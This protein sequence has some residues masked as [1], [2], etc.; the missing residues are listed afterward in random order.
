MVL[1]VAHES[2]QNIISLKHAQ[3]TL[4]SPPHTPM[5]RRHAVLLFSALIWCVSSPSSHAGQTFGGAA[6]RT[7]IRADALAH[8]QHQL[9]VPDTLALARATIAHAS[10]HARHSALSKTPE[11]LFEQARDALINRQDT[12]VEA[13]LQAALDDPQLNATYQDSARLMLARLY[14]E[15]RRPHDALPLLDR[16]GTTPIR[17]YVWWTH[18]R[19]L[20]EAGRHH[21]AAR[22]YERV[23]KISASPMAHR[24][25]VMRAHA[26][27]KAQD[28]RAAADALASTAKLYPDY[29]RRHIQLAQ[30]A[31]T[32]ERL[33]QPKEA[34]SVY[35]TL[36]LDYPFRREG[37][38]ARQRLDALS[39]KGVRPRA[40]SREERYAKYRHLRWFRHWGTARE[41]LQQ[42]ER[43]TIEADGLHAELTHRIWFQLALNAYWPKDYTEAIHYLNK[44]ADAYEKGHRDGLNPY[45]F[46]RYR[47]FSLARIGRFKDALT[48]LDRAYARASE[49][50]RTLRRANFLAEHGKYTEARTLYTKVKPDSWFETWDG[51]WLLYKTR[52]YERAIE[53]FLRLADQRSRWSSSRAR[54]LY[55]AARAE[56]RR[57]RTAEARKLFAQVRLE[58]ADTYYGIQANNR[59]HDMRQRERFL[60][61][62][63]LQTDTLVRG[64][65]ALQELDRPVASAQHSPAS[66]ERAQP[67][68]VL[69]QPA[70]DVERALLTPM[71][72][73][74]V[75]AGHETL[76]CAIASELGYLP[77]ALPPRR[78]TAP[79]L[80]VAAHTPA[81]S[82]RTLIPTPNIPLYHSKE[83]ARDRIPYAA[84]ARIYW[85][86]RNDSALAFARYEDGEAI[87]PVPSRLTAYDETSHVGGLERA[88]VAAGELFGELGRAQWLFRIGMRKQARWAIRD[89]ALEYRDLLAK[90]RPQRAPHQ[91]DRKRMVP[92]ID[93]RKRKLAT[94]GYTEEEHRWPVPDNARARKALLERQQAIYDRRRELR[95]I[96]IDAFKEV[97]DYYMVRRMTLDGGYSGRQRTMQLWPRAFPEEV[98]PAAR[99]FGINPYLVWGIMTTESTYNPDSISWARAIGLMQVI[100]RTGFK[101]AQL[102]GEE[103]FGHDDLLEEDVAIRH[104]AFYLGR[105]VRKFNG[106]ELFAMAGYNGGPHRISDMIDQRGD[107]PLDEFIEEIPFNEARNYAKK[108]TRTIA[109]YLRIY[110]GIDELYIGQNIRREFT[111]MPNF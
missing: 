46:Y 16:I 100:P 23:A 85:E 97:G 107:M 36:W 71:R 57:G 74:P 43:E 75:E 4:P 63:A 92:Y 50:E 22:Y 38:Q 104:G 65:S 2:K 58:H 52:D 102:L 1:V 111:Y 103:H 20:D 49:D 53:V 105:L 48:D 5:K 47:A 55:W 89:V 11:A 56:E 67:R 12:E 99:R 68:T 80:A 51:A 14:L 39:S 66:D 10:R 64:T 101:T 40:L 3:L 21:D 41:L 18:A 86:G 88:V 94:W 35:Q 84:E 42:L 87:G 13:L 95:P 25:R 17:D 27:Y 62:F 26:L 76:T 44:C 106:Q 9:H 77:A 91:L 6:A 32:Y 98:I 15:Q 83:N 60:G 70:E 69:L 93:L 19:A 28:W 8:V 79:P 24:A 109:R 73:D 96:L 30:L 61:A 34:V 78:L 37:R 54:Y 33:D 72:C 90:R 31:A 110:E 81:I 108:V 45:S 29:P 59:L 7:P 82:E